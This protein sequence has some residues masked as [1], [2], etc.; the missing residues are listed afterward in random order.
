DLIFTHGGG[1]VLMWLGGGKFINAPHTGANVRT[2]RGAP[3]GIREVRRYIGGG[4]KFDNGTASRAAGNNRDSLA[5]GSSDPTRS[6]TQDANGDFN[7]PSLTMSDFMLGSSR[8]FANELGSVS[9]K[10]ALEGVMVTTRQMVDAIT[11]GVLSDTSNF[12]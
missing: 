1:H 8:I 2:G 3:G 5:N 12:S 7:Q 11:S 4:Q 10:D 6:T 9:E